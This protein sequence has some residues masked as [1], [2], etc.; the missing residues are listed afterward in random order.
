LELLVCEFRCEPTED[1]EIGVERT[2]LDATD[3]EHRQRVAMLRPAE[4]ALDG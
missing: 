4:L 2:A 1:G 3:A